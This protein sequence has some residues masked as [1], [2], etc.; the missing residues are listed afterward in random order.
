MNVMDENVLFFFKVL[1]DPKNN[2]GNDEKR[3]FENSH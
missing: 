3:V 2:T 1:I